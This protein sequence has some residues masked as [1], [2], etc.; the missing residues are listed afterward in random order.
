[1]KKRKHLLRT[2]LLFSLFMVAA[3]PWVQAADKIAQLVR[4]MLELMS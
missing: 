4:V 2:A 1:M 3:V